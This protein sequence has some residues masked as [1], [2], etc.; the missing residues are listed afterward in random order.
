[1]RHFKKLK[2]NSKEHMKEQIHK[3]K[4]FLEKKNGK[5]D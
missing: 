4:K 1:M 3:T 5:I 2:N